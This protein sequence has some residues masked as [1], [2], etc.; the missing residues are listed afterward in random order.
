MRVAGRLSLTQHATELS[1][2]AAWL[3]DVIEDCGVKKD[4][5]KYLFGETVADWVDWLTNPSKDSKVLRA[6]RKAMDRQHASEAP[7]IVQCIK[8]LDR[9][10]NLNEIDP[11]DSF[12]RLYCQESALLLEAIGPADPELGQ[13]LADAIKRVSAAAHKSTSN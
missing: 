10:D 12:A 1:V 8:L 7:P 6:E 2:S 9:I 3:H 13:E 4:T 5:I 11:S